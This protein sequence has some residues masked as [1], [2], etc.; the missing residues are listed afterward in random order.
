MFIFVYPNLLNI[1]YLF[2]VVFEPSISIYLSGRTSII[3][4]S[5]LLFSGIKLFNPL[6]K[7]LCLRASTRLQVYTRHPP[8]SPNPDL[9]PEPVLMLFHAAHLTVALEIEFISDYADNDTV[10]LPYQSHGVHT[11]IGFS[12]MI[13]KLNGKVPTY[14]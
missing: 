7:P 9:S 3:T 6:Q 14:S 8:K 10:R 13:F 11:I 1:S 4:Y 2:S 12:R 5:S